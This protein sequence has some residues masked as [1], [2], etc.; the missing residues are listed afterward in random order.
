MAESYNLKIDAGADFFL[1]LRFKDESGVYL[2]LTGH[3]AR[4]MLK[5]K[6]DSPTPLLSLTS[7]SNGITFSKWE[8]ELDPWVNTVSI[9][10]TNVQTEQ[11]VDYTLLDIDG[12]VEFGEGVYDL[13]ILDEAQL[14]VRAI[15]G[16]W[17]ASPEVTK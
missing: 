13:E 9:H 4:M 3:T 17:I 16:Y 10:I 5:N 12:D 1:S 6:H 2:E 8:P 15:Q 11:L 7:P 14:V